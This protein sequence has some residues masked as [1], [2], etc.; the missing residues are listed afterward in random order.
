[1]KYY[2]YAEDLCSA[3]IGPFDTKEDAEAHVKFCK[4][5]GDCATMDILTAD[6]ADRGSKMQ[7]IGMRLTPEEDRRWNAEEDRYESGQG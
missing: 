2:I 1:M 4:E 5:R 7:E 6:E 3:L